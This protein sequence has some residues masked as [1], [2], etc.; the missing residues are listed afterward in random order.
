MSSESNI[1][2]QI[3]LALKEWTEPNNGML[4]LKEENK[5]K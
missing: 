4:S 5:I 3:Y 2:I 1:Q